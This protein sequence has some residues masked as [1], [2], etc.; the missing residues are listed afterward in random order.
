VV[1]AAGLS[2]F[3]A[4]CAKQEAA[5]PAPRGAGGG[6]ATPVLVAQAVTKTVPLN[7]TAIGNVEPYSTVSIRAQVAGELLEVNFTEGDSVSKGQLLFTIDPRPY[8]AALAQAKA[9][10][11]RDKAT[12][13]NNRVQADRYKK[14]LAEGVV[15]AQQVD[16]FTAA[17]DSSDAVVAS[18]EAAIQTSELNLSYCKI[19]A[20]I[21]GRTGNVMVKAGNLVKVSDVPMVVINQ[22]NPVYVNFTVPQQSLPDVKR[23]MAEHSL[24][25]EA[26]VP[27][28]PGPVEQGA[29]TFVD[30]SVDP[31]TGTIHL[32]ATFAN[33]KN[34]LWPG[35]FV[36]TLLTLS[37]VPNAVTIPT[38]AIASGTQGTPVVYVVKPNNTVEMRSVTSSRNIGPDAIIETGL[39]A[40]ETVVT[41]GQMRLVPGAR[42]QVRS[43]DGDNSQVKQGPDSGDPAGKP[44]DPAAKGAGGG[45]GAKQ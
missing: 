3:A 24:S 28:D 7:L 37:Q 32:K 16:T 21:S 5:A 34:R 41:D 15:P 43:S 44:G 36:N 13:A 20:P 12:S 4:G 35:L 23:Y 31:S 1:L 29:L 39:K 11:A 26:T 18:D 19:Y 27:N 14:L 10:L 40:G 38:Q 8:E 2:L 22:V 42:I 25:V 33:T 17:A 6:P 30:N 9:A 45:Q